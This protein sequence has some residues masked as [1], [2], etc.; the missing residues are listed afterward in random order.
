VPPGEA[1][2]EARGPGDE[3]DS[4]EELP[5]ASSGEAGAAKE[6][7]RPKIPPGPLTVDLALLKYF[8]F[9][10]NNQGFEKFCSHPSNSLKFSPNIPKSFDLSLVA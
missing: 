8:T 5:G 7:V 2:T 4:E 6:R 9:L 1:D 10:Q 3:V